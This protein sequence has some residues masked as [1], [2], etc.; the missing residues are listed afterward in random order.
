MKNSILPVVILFFF[1]QIKTQDGFY[2][3]PKDSDNWETQSIEDAGWCPDQMDALMQELEDNQTKAFIVLK[4]GKIVIEEYFD[5]FKQ[6]SS[7][8]WFSAGKSLTAFLTGLAQ[9]QGLLNIEDATSNYLGSSWSSLE[10]ENENMITIRNQLSMT[11]GLDYNVDDPFCTDAECLQ[12]LNTPNEHWYYHNAPYS[13]LRDVL[14]NATG[15]NISVYTFLELHQKTGMDGLWLP[16]GFNNFFISTAR[17]M[18]RF[19]LLM[20]NNGDWGETTIMNDKNYLQEMTTS[21]QSLNPA[22]G[23]LWWLNGKTNHKLPG[24]DLVYNGPLDNHAPSDMYCAVG[25]S[26]Q[27]LCI[28]PSQEIVMVRMGSSNLTGLVPIDLLN[29]I[30]EKFQSLICNTSSIV[31]IKA[32]EK[33]V[34]IYPNPINGNEL[35][36]YIKHTRNVRLEVFNHQSKRLLIINNYNSGRIAFDFPKGIYYIKLKDKSGWSSVQKIVKI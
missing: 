36:V 7:W 5:G 25:A 1:S 11:T 20:L 6:D 33:S 32:E 27:I 35:N 30:S 8:I 10:G 15:R 26:G 21:S 13:L 34:D 12:F 28:I 16:S 18:A 3:P 14:E 17:S 29:K 22:Y 24:S 9:E 2:F 19:G 31:N 4:S 23:L